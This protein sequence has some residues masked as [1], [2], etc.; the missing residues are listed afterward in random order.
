MP[1]TQ[2]TR[3]LIVLAGFFLGALSVLVVGLLMQE[4]STTE[5]QFAGT[6]G[7]R[8]GTAWQGIRPAFEN[9]AW[10]DPHNWDVGV[11]NG[12][13][14]VIVSNSSLTGRYNLE[15]PQPDGGDTART[16]DLIVESGGRV[17]FTT[18]SEHALMVV[19]GTWIV[20]DQAIVDL[21]SGTLI[22]RGDVVIESG[23][24]CDAGTG[25]IIFAGQSWETNSLS[26]FNAGGSKIVFEGASVQTISGEISCYDLE[27]HTSDT[28]RIQGR[29]SVSHSVTIAAGTHVIVEAGGAINVSG[30][31]A[32]QGTIKGFGAISISG[33]DGA[34]TA[35][36]TG[37]QV[38]ETITLRPNYPNPF[39]PSTT[40]EF[41]VLN[42]EPTS[43]RVFDIQGREIR[44]L[45]AD[46]T[47]PGRT[48]QVTFNASG[49][50]SGTY[51]Y[52]LQ[53][54]NQRKVGRMILQ[55]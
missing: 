6:I 41:S 54:G 21:G 45:F 32:N 20:R 30:S 53:S 11:P 15:I 2:R 1:G 17:T 13:T 28:L 10:F 26:A 29:V 50:A 18:P 27:V 9:P 12:E 31:V 34:S 42:R 19:E 25:I 52:V 35:M 48:Y 33:A 44:T 7:I 23:A 51:I 22:V 46:M 16:H 36:N 49:L 47:D 43:L 38:P 39:N 55:K 37:T 4:R 5:T 8:G 40:I 14:D 24:K 3:L